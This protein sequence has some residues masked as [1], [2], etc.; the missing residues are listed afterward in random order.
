MFSIGYF[1]LY[2][3]GMIEI[4]DSNCYIFFEI[5]ECMDSDYRM[6]RDSAITKYFIYN[7]INKGNYTESEFIN[8]NY[9]KINN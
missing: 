5:H 7:K 3:I 9:I 1:T 8:A 6:P 2:Y 4:T